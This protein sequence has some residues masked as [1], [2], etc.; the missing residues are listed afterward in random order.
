MEWCYQLKKKLRIFQSYL[1]FLQEE[2]SHVKNTAAGLRWR[3]F[4][5]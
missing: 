3:N 4:K 1:H 5:L 2:A